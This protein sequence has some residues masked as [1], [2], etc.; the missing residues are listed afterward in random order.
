MSQTG[1]NNLRTTMDFYQ[2]A[3]VGNR[4]ADLGHTTA[5]RRDPGLLFR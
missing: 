2:P 5:G 4:Q 3:T 1:N